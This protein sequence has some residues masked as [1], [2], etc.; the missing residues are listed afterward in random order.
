M[1][2]S[3]IPNTIGDI[4]R[5]QAH[6]VGTRVAYTFQGTD[7][8]FATFDLHTNQ[9][10]NGLLGSGVKPGS[11]ICYLGRNSEAYFEVVFGAA[12]AGAVI[13]PIN[14]RLAAPEIAYILEDCRAEVLFTEREFLS[15]LDR[16]NIT[17][18]FC[19][20]VVSSGD[21]D[22][23]FEMWR[24]SQP[25]TDPAIQV[26][27]EAPVL[28][29]YT[30]GTTGRP[31]G[32][33]LSHGNILGPRQL[34]GDRFPDWYQ[35]S[36]T[37]AALIA[38]PVFHVG[39]TGLGITTLF[40]GARG[41]IAREFDPAGVVEFIE[42]DRITKLLMVPS[43]LQ[44]LLS[45][46]KSRGADYS[47]LKYILYGASPMPPNLLRECLELFPCKF[48]QTYGMTETAGAIVALGPA[49]HDPIGNPR[50]RSAG[51]TLPGVEICIT[52]TNGD[53]LPTGATGE[54]RTRSVANMVGYW[55]LPEETD[56]AIDADGWLRT[57][58]AGYLDDDGYLYVVDRI[59]DVIIS[60]GE[61]IYAAELE[62]ILSQHPN[63][64]EV[65]VIGIPDTRW[66][67]VPLAIVVQK[68]GCAITS[69]DILRFARLSVASFKVPK[70]VEF[71]S[72]LPRNA[73]GK[74]LRRQ[75]RE[76]YWPW[77]TQTPNR[78]R[79]ES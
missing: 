19:K 26:A 65:A 49:D 76:P 32:A 27:R 9:V 4:P 7:T 11:R 45:N 58:D 3:P 47:S 35:W 75:L 6:S 43:A 12:K 38:V 62:R 57:G 46:P 55:N 61:N 23:G 17:R 40:H 30:S 77:K 73:S 2:E 59:K 60:G 10:A 64:A 50:M 33:M 25:A 14:W 16:A 72:S 78:S 21:G 29:V 42:R 28:Q 67:E 74:I 54:I 44:M 1:K 48:V 15:P 79:D 51:K 71:V 53:L 52:D 8:D 39:G 22:I 24:Q 69:E 68:D 18:Q 37:D 70:A 36:A 63:I 20:L 13:A 56:D 5:L 66:G 31:K 34:H 41:V